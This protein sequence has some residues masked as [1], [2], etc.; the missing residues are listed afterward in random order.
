MKTQTKINLIGRTQ[1]HTIQF[2]IN[3]HTLKQQILNNKKQGIHA[4]FVLT[5]KH[6]LVFFS[7]G[8]HLFLGKF[9]STLFVSTKINHQTKKKI[10]LLLFLSVE[11]LLFSRCFFLPRTH[12]NTKPHTPTK[13]K[14]KR[15]LFTTKK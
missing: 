4:A 5:Q 15:F 3:T 2:Q 10:F 1:Q 7:I 9:T 11:E 12:A 6:A 13:N 8:K 14:M